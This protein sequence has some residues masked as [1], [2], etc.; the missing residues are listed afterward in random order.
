M[1]GD[2]STPIPRHGPITDGQSWKKIVRHL[3]LNLQTTDDELGLV[4]TV[5]ARSMKQHVYVKE[6]MSGLD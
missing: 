6:L 1:C 4:R 2:T 3:K 5:C